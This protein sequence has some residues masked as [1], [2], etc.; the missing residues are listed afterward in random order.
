[1]P[2]ETRVPSSFAGKHISHLHAAGGYNRSI[3]WAGCAADCDR[4][5]RV[6]GVAEADCAHRWSNHVDGVDP[7]LRCQPSMS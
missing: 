2:H 6:R 7:L 1:M 3:G 4:L 5:G